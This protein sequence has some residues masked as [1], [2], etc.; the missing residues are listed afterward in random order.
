MLCLLLIHYAN[1]K[2][3]LEPMRYLARTFTYRICILYIY[4]V[5]H[6]YIYKT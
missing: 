2:L 4:F 1:A 6:Q 5:H 3:K